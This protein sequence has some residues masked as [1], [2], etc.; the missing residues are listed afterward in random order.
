M[1]Y[2]I[3]LGINYPEREAFAEW[4]RKRGHKVYLSF[5]GESGILRPIEPEEYEDEFSELCCQ[6]EMRK[7]GHGSQDQIPAE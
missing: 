6:F 5:V 4:L 2:E 1:T 3:E 7:S